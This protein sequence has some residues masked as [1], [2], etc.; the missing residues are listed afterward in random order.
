MKRQASLLVGERRQVLA[1]SGP[2]NH[3][4]GF[5][6]CQPSA[7]SKDG[8]NIGITRPPVS[9]P[10][11]HRQATLSGHPTPHQGAANIIEVQ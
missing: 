6:F 2:V 11:F 10:R 1:S 9:S 4:D 5:C 3:C 7:V 8:V